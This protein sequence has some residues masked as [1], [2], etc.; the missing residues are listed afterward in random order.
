VQLVA[1]LGQ[2]VA[3]GGVDDKNDGVDAAKMVPPQRAD[4]LLAAEVLSAVRIRGGGWMYPN[5]HFYAGKDVRLH[6]W[7]REGQ[8][9]GKGEVR[10]EGDGEGVQT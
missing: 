3:V 2:A 7:G 10:G 6:C 4:A 9:V 5:D 8:G 1:R